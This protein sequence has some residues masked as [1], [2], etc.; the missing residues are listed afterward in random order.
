[1]AAAAILKIAF[2]GHMSS[3][4]FPISAKFC[5]RKHADKGYETKTENF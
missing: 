4:D 2:F 3:T 5:M 1:M